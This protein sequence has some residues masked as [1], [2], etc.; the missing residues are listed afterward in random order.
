MAT[1]LTLPTPDIWLLAGGRTV[2]AFVPRHAI[3][4]NDEIELAAGAARP[5]S[6]LR[7]GY[8]YA[9]EPPESGDLAALVI[10]VQ[11]ASSLGSEAESNF[12]TVVQEGDVLILRVYRGEHPVLDDTEFERRRAEVEADFR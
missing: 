7:P 4:L 1:S 3:D 2:V 11:P 12:L 10:G 9:G 6:D 8:G 5:E